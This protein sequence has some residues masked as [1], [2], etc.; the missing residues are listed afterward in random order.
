MAVNTFLGTT[1]SN[2]GTATNWSQGTVPTSTDTHTTTFDAA[3][4]ACTVDTSDR[5]C[6]RV[7]FT[8]YTNTITMTFGLY[9]YGNITLGAG[10]SVAGAASSGF[11]Y[12]Y[13]TTASITSNGYVFPNDFYIGG[14]T[15]T[16][17]LQDDLYVSGG[18]Y[19]NRLVNT[20]VLNG[21]KIFVSGNLSVGT[22]VTQIQIG[23]TV[24]EITGGGNQ[25]WNGT[26]QFRNSVI[27]N[28]S[29]GTLTLSG[30]INYNTGTLTHTAGTVDAGTTIFVNA[31]ATIYNTGTGMTFY[32]I[33][34]NGNIT[35]NSVLQA[36]TIQLVTISSFLGT[37]GFVVNT[38]QTQQQGITYTFK[39]GLT[40]VV[41]TG[42]YL[43][44]SYLTHCYVFSSVASSK[45]YLTFNGLNSQQKIF[46]VDFTDIDASGGNKIWSY[47]G[48]LL[49]TTNV[50]VSNSSIVPVTV[51]KTF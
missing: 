12:L 46:N 20:T 11:L 41:N 7:D 23:T 36:D 42:L 10:M 32:Q 6:N 24:I 44:S 43:N 2:W 47:D 26:G 16:V 48:V 35:L 19:L 37:A 39:A 1:D 40:Y 21:F 18:L 25:T 31:S 49:R 4:P 33:N 30:T 9:V 50:G 45:A 29:G 15:K 28:K 51:S 34:T 27:I 17:T 3:S 14:S 13:N 5:V 8:N 38:L 22:A